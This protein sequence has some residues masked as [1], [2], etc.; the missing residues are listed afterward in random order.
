MTELHPCLK[1]FV[2]RLRDAAE[3]VHAISDESK[4]F[5]EIW[6]N[7]APAI[8]RMDIY[9][10]TTSLAERVVKWGDGVAL[11][12]TQVEYIE[13]T[14]NNFKRLVDDV[15]PNLFS[16]PQSSVFY[17]ATISA[18]DIAF[19]RI[20]SSQWNVIEDKKMMP[21]RLSRLIDAQAERLRASTA[22]LD[23][24]DE[25]VKAINDAHDVVDNFP[26][27]LAQIREWQKELGVIQK[28]ASDNIAAID[29]IN[30]DASSAKGK[31]EGFISEGAAL[32]KQLQ[33]LH[34]VGT[35]TT[36]AG[37]FNEKAKSLMWSMW[38]WVVFLS[39]S[40]IGIYYI[41]HERI[42]S[43]SQYMAA[44]TIN[45]DGVWINVVLTLL[46]VSPPVWLA[47]LASKQIGQRFKLAEDYA[48]KASISNAYEGYRR[49]A[50]N[51]DPQFQARLFGTALTRLE[52]IPI[53]LV[54][55][56]NHGSPLHEF[57]NSIPFQEA[58][59]KVGGFKDSFVDFLKADPRKDAKEKI[60][61]V[62][63]AAS[64]AVKTATKTPE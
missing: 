42:G 25:K 16:N 7:Q 43:I 49:E 41:G 61:E 31:I 27:D 47:W 9:S 35:S 21:A 51:M 3:K 36:L 10:M 57:F 33:D 24:I 26:A 1:T 15:I 52:E 55:Q 18:L 29:Q 44:E 38:I 8:D 5:S 37:A 20:S 50:V 32:V 45:W 2:S 39:L 63:E 60:K 62:T 58:M 14:E 6:P 40:L 64:D 12:S 30:K 28:T 48:Y 11:N 17:V 53:R 59:D 4:T 13:A 34:Q 19:S 56:G 22:K 54:D 46:S 23:D